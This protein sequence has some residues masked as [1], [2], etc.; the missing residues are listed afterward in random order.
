MVVNNRGVTLDLT[1][2]L[3]LATLLRSFRERTTCRY[4]LITPSTQFTWKFFWEIISETIRIL[5]KGLLW[6]TYRVESGKWNT[7]IRGWSSRSP[8][9]LNIFKL[10]NIWLFNFRWIWPIVSLFI[11]ISL[12]VKTSTSIDCCCYSFV[13]K[14]VMDLIKQ[15]ISLLLE[16]TLSVLL[17]FWSS[18]WLP[19]INFSEAVIIRDWFII[20]TY[21]YF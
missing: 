14:V 8:W 2:L 20:P 11:F 17:G 16:R 1:R 4:T 6:C 19:F 13:A 7:M 5:R 9:P 21:I 18:S 10:L 15:I 12:W 3:C